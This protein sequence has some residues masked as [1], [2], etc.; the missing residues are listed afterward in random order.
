LPQLTPT[1]L[2]EFD[3]THR[4]SPHNSLSFP[5]YYYNDHTTPL[6]VSFGVGRRAN[7]RGY[8]LGGPV[9]GSRGPF[10]AERVDSTYESGTSR[11][12]IAVAVSG[13]SWTNS[14]RC[15]PIVQDTSPKFLMP[16][17]YMSITNVHRSVLDAGRER[18]SV[19][20][21]LA[22]VLA[23]IAAGKLVSKQIHVNSIA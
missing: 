10:G 11:R 23:V 20:A 14:T 8:R 22:L 6:A 1:S 16:A 21:I 12:R 9:G 3:L 19:A 5:D 15:I 17:G 7:P 18:L 2:M 4:F 13:P